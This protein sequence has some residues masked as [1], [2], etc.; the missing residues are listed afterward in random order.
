MMPADRDRLE[1]WSE[2]TVIGRRLLFPVWGE[3]ILVGPVSHE[4]FNGPGLRGRVGW[5]DVAKGIGISLVVFGHNLGGLRESGILNNSWGEFTERYIYI[6]HMPLFFFLAGL[7]VTQSAQRAFG[8]YFANKVSVIAYPYFVWSLLEGS[9]QIF[10][11]RFT[12]NHLSLTDL[13]KIVYQP[14]D[15]FWFLYVIFLMYIAY[16]F[17][18]HGRVSSNIVLF[19]SVLIQIIQIFGLNIVRWDVFNSFCHFLIYFALG[20][21][22][23]DTSLLTNFS[24]FNRMRLSCFAVGGYLFIAITLIA[25]IAPTTPN[26]SSLLVIKILLSLLGI[27]ATIALS[28][29]SCRSIVGPYLR[30]IGLYSLEIYV[31]HTIFASGA[32]IVIQRSFGYTAPALHLVVETI[33]GISVPLLL[34]TFGPKVGLP[35][36]FTCSRLRQSMEVSAIRLRKA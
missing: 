10:A 29:L 21:K 15:Q 36:L 33:V 22:I 30:I 6:F 8:V 16:W 13:L 20:V 4:P 2:K 24:A 17:V 9:I 11:S 34:A 23:A 14:I 19:G 1:A 35:Y 18:H 12:N 27:T 25:L 26:V 7:F 28:M 32:R 31:G 3:P 5:V